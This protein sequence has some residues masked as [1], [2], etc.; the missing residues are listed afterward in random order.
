MPRQ[1]R[2]LRHR[3]S[4]PPMRLQTFVLRGLHCGAPRWQAAAAGAHF[5]AVAPAAAAWRA[6]IL[7]RDWAIAPAESPLLCRQQ[8]AA[9]MQQPPSCRPWMQPPSASALLLAGFEWMPRPAG[10]C[11]AAGLWARPQAVRCSDASVAAALLRATLA[12][13]TPHRPRAVRAPRGQAR[14]AAGAA[15]S[16]RRPACVARRRP[17]RP[18]SPSLLCTAQVC[19]R[20]SSRSRLRA[21]HRRQPRLGQRGQ[22]R[23][24]RIQT[25]RTARRPGS[26]RLAYCLQQPPRCTAAAVAAAAQTGSPGSMLRV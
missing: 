10:S 18:A 8:A 17:R 9:A 22:P 26:P 7:P 15:A 11:P 12:M 6:C 1:R 14:A 24:L 3:S 19:P 5:P 16:A 4:R 25:A 13:P 20:T 23:M 21:L 2:L